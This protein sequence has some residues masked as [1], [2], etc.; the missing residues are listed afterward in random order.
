MRWKFTRAMDQRLRSAQSG[1][2]I[3]FLRER[4]RLAAVE[5]SS[6]ATRTRETHHKVT[7]GTKTLITYAL[8]ALR[9]FVVNSLLSPSPKSL[10]QSHVQLYARS[11]DG[12]ALRRFVR[13]IRAPG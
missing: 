9:V 3:R 10:P 5:G 11:K 12:P 1:A 7:K 8:S 13:T 6:G 2:P 4:I